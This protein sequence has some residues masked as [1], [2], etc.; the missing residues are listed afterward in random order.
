MA[1]L[2]IQSETLIEIKKIL[3]GNTSKVDEAKNPIND[4]EN[5]EAKN[6]QS[7]QQEEKRSQKNEDSVSSLW[8]NFKQSS[9]HFTGVP[10][11]EEKKQETGNLFEKNNERQLP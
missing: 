1:F 3:Q 6:N 7:E 9:I 5:K 10:E 2:K 4:L 11:G 8:D